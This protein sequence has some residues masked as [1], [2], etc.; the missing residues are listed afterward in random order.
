L[1][2]RNV[3]T[4]PVK[5]SKVLAPTRVVDTGGGFLIEEDISDGQSSTQVKIIH[6]PG[7][8]EI[9]VV[10]LTHFAFSSS[11]KGDSIMEL[12]LDSGELSSLLIFISYLLQHHMTVKW[13]LNC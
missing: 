10:R 11:A 2:D 3:K 8:F 1:F 5:I 12:N 7:L 9:E 13:M 4:G 6:E